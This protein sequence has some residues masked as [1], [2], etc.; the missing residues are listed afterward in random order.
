V[1]GLER[2]GVP[3]EGMAAAVRDGSLSF[4]FMD[5]AAFDRFPGLSNITFHELSERTGI[6]MDLLKVAREA[7]GFAE[8]RLEDLVRR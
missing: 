2:T 6:P 8:P 1:Q 5:V 4:S 3:L 7:V